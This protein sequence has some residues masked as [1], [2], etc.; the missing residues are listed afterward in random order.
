MILGVVFCCWV[1]IE[2]LGVEFFCEERRDYVSWV[3]RIKSMD[4]MFFWGV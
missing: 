4:V 2:I 3:V 1:Y